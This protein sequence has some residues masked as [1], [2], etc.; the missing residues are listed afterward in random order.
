M[1]YCLVLGDPIEHSLSPVIHREAYRVL[2]LDWEFHPRRLRPEQLADFLAQLDEDCRGLAVTM[3]LKPQALALATYRDGLAKVTGAVNTLVPGPGGTWAGFN[4]DVYGIVQAFREG[5]DETRGED[6][7]ALP[8]ETRV[9]DGGGVF[10]TRAVFRGA[11]AV[12]AGFEGLSFG[13]G[14]RCGRDGTAGGASPERGFTSPFAPD[15]GS[16]SRDG[17]G[18]A[19][20]AGI[21]ARLCWTPA[22]VPQC[23][24][25][26]EHH[27]RSPTVPTRATEPPPRCGGAGCGLRSLAHPGGALGRD[28]GREG[29]RGLEHVVASSSGAAETL[30]RC[31]SRSRASARSP[32]IRTQ[33]GALIR[34]PANQR[35]E[36]CWDFT[37]CLGW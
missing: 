16:T 20:G 4:T 23:P 26:D 19:S 17:D 33:Q 3:P 1:Y 31:R 15:P 21:L 9:E 27:P 10:G 34:G 35:R 14:F 24:L 13:S 12:S 2:G 6:G 25:G 29:D 7:G 18:G 8:G 32:G 30:Y 36:T 28:G 5:I 22:A 11:S 37:W